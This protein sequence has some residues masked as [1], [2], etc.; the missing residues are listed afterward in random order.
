MAN[1]EIESCEA[2]HDGRMTMGNMGTTFHADK[3]L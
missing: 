1:G 3:N 2:I